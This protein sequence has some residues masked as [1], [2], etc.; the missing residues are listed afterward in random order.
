VGSRTHGRVLRRL[1]RARS[2]RGSRTG[3]RP[4]RACTTHIRMLEGYVRPGDGCSTPARARPVHA[5]AAAARRP[6]HRARHLAGQL[7]LL[8]GARARRRG[9]GRRHHRPLAVRRRRVRRHGLLRRPDQLRRRSRWK[10]VAE[11]ARVTRPGGHVVV[12]VMG[13][14]AR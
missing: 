8:R 7:E 14:A 12:S 6:R 2:G 9:G 4:A 11:L 1:R 5:R 3:G 10:A 13:S